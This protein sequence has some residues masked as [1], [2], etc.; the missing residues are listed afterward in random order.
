[1]KKNSK[2]VLTFA[3]SVVYYNCKEIKE[4][5]T[6]KNNALLKMA[7][8]TENAKKANALQRARKATNGT[9]SKKAVIAE[10]KKNA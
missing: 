1:M 9:W 3:G 10:I 7:T 4:I 2:K 6:M 5:K 8:Y